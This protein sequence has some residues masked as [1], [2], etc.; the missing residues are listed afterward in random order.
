MSTQQDME[1]DGQTPRRAAG[2]EKVIMQEK[3]LIQYLVAKRVTGEQK[4]R[5]D[6]ERGSAEQ[7]IAQKL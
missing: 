5:G 2:A 4:Q 3:A 1:D 7:K 6:Q